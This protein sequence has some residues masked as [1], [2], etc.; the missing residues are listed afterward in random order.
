M[1]K[2]LDSATVAINAAGV[3]RNNNTANFRIPEI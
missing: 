1:G 3:A 2:L